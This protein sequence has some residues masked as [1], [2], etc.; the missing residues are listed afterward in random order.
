M[1]EEGPPCG[2]RK[3]LGKSSSSDACSEETEDGEAQAQDEPGRHSLSCLL[4]VHSV[5]SSPGSRLMRYSTASSRVRFW[6]LVSFT[7]RGK[8]LRHGP[9]G[10]MESAGTSGDPRG[11]SAQGKVGG[12]T[13]LCRSS[14]CH[15]P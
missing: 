7:C 1:W 6:K 14:A 12:V 5:M 4:W 2:G 8:A 9:T 11:G 10:G 3:G 13:G 15:N